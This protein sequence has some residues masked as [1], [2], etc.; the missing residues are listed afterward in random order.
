MTNRLEIRAAHAAVEIMCVE[1]RMFPFEKWST[2]NLQV[3]EAHLDMLDSLVPPTERL[4]E[5]QAA[6]VAAA[7]EVIGDEWLVDAPATEWVVAYWL[8]KIDEILT[9]PEV[10]G[11]PAC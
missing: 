5:V 2:Q 9:A 4:S 7:L 6:A 11:E 3:L 10:S 8:G 1:K